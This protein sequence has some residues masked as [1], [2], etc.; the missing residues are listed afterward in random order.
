MKFEVCPRPV[1]VPKPLGRPSRSPHYDLATALLDAVNSRQA[2]QVTI[3]LSDGTARTAWQRLLAG[4]MSHV[5]YRTR[6]YVG[7]KRYR[8]R[9]QEVGMTVRV[10]WLERVPPEPADLTNP[11]RFGYT[12]SKEE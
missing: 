9:Q 5:T 1:P 3:E 6:E 4:L 12:P 8:L 11:K 10:L 2:I 7:D